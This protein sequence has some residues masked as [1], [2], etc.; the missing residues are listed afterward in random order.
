LR[1][2]PPAAETTTTTNEIKPLFPSHS[3]PLSTIERSA[4]VTLHLEGYD[5]NY[6]SK[7]IPYQ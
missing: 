4:I 6:I 3:I 7:H 2:R 5:V 1:S